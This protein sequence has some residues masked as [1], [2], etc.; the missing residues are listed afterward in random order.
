[1][2]D[3]L[4]GASPIP[5][6]RQPYPL[7]TSASDEHLRPSPIQTGEFGMY[8]KSHKQPAHH[9]EKDM[10]VAQRQRIRT[11]RPIK[12][13]PCSTSANK[14][15]LNLNLA[16]DQNRPS[17]ASSASINTAAAHRRFPPQVQQPLL[18]AHNSSPFLPSA[19]KQQ[20]PILPHPS[21]TTDTPRVQKRLLTACLVCGRFLFS[22]AEKKYTR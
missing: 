3:F 21:A 18:P 19:T 10:P 4:A 5:F 20:Q 12:P 22:H 16:F 14:I 17:P 11:P 1:M 8:Q 2:G 13:H 15:S 7:R 9:Q 6:A